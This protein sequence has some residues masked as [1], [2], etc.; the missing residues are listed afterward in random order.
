MTEPAYSHGE[1]VEWL[2][3]R[4]DHG[5]EAVTRL[6]RKTAALSS[7]RFSAPFSPEQGEVKTRL[8]QMSEFQQT[9]AACSSPRLQWPAGCTVRAS[10]LPAG[11][12]QTGECREADNPAEEKTAFGRPRTRVA[13]PCWGRRRRLPQVPWTRVAGMKEASRQGCGETPGVAVDKSS[14]CEGGTFGDP[15]EST[16]HGSRQPRHS[17]RPYL[18]LKSRTNHQ[19]G[20]HATTT[21]AVWR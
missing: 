20:G 7:S 16:K 13:K 12:T 2:R 19:Q 6:L 1:A 5:R 21:R 10:S 17:R 15:G 18:S 9:Q 11:D 8:P 14:A 4:A 3:A